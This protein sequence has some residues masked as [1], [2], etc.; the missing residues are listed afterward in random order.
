MQV[1]VVQA[2]IGYCNETRSS[3]VSGRKHVSVVQAR[4]G[5]C[6]PQRDSTV[7]PNNG[8]SRSGANRLLQLASLRLHPIRATRVSRSGANRLLQ[9][10][11]CCGLMVA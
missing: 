5:Y 10:R 9:Q 6:N 1:S 8:V 7:T 11:F 3:E 4:I 2:R